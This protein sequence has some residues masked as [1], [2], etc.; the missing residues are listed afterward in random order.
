MT[1]DILAITNEVLEIFKGY[2]LSRVQTIFVIEAVKLSIN[3]QI[4]R[5]TIQD[6]KKSYDELPGVL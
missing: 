3:E 2:E 4:I 6:E 5:E 1:T